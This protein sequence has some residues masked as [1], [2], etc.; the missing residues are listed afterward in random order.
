MVLT[1]GPMTFPAA[2]IPHFGAVIGGAFA[3]LVALE[4]G[5]MTGLCGCCLS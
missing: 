5:G 1:I 2:Y 3:V 4:A